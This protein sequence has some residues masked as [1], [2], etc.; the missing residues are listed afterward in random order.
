MLSALGVKLD[1]TP[2]AAARC[3][4]ETGIVFM[5]APKHHLSMKHAIGPRQEIGIRTIFNI[6]GPLANPALADAQVMGVFAPDLTEKLGEVLLNLGVKRGFVVHGGDGMDEITLTDYTKITEIKDQK[7][8]TYY[9]KP[10]ELGLERTTLS[11]LKGGDTAEN[12]DIIKKILSGKLPGP[13]TDIVLLNAAAAIVAGGLAED[14]GEGLLLARRS[15]ESGKALHKLDELIR[16][17]TL[18]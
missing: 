10:E 1:I 9:L 13:K 12:A 5:F 11:E 8:R 2:E 17:S 18:N 14:L 4:A 6:L 15:L 16:V 3:L 7:T